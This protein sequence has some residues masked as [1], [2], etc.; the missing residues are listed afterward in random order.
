MSKD[1]MKNDFE[2]K[3]EL[4]KQMGLEEVLIWINLLFEVLFENL[5]DHVIQTLMQ[6]HMEKISKIGKE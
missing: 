5:P 1:F 3:L 4:M 2:K 6:K